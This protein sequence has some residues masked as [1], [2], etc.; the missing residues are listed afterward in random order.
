M[1]ILREIVDPIEDE[2]VMDSFN[3]N[4]IVDS[5][6]SNDLEDHDL[7]GNNL[8]SPYDYA[9]GGRNRGESY[10]YYPVEGPIEDEG[11]I[12]TD[13]SIEILVD[14]IDAFD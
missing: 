6:Q 12:Q 2:I 5:S 4:N 7:V 14:D 11:D 10:G 8:Y 13:I 3:L 9:G 1:N